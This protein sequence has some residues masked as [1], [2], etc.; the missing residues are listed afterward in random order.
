M[1][2]EA[3]L[4]WETMLTSHSSASSSRQ[5]VGNVTLPYTSPANGDSIPS[6][7]WYICALH[8]DV[9]TAELHIAYV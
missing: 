4:G 6:H 3:V 8:C 7:C 5:T 9:D 1:F 2:V